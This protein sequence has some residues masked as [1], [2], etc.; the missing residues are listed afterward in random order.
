MPQP[1]M[2]TLTRPTGQRFVFRF[3]FWQERQLADVVNELVA[4]PDRDFSQDDAIGVALAYATVERA[5]LD[6]IN[7]KVMGDL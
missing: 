5:A 6:A 4:D 3:R 2:I 1:C 7:E